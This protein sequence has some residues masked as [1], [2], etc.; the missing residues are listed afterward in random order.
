[1]TINR[2][3]EPPRIKGGTCSYCCACFLHLFNLYFDEHD[4]DEAKNVSVAKTTDGYMQ[5]GNELKN[6]STLSEP[7]KQINWRSHEELNKESSGDL[8]AHV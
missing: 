6:R 5:H 7:N 2:K 3:Q 1:M 8:T 4:P